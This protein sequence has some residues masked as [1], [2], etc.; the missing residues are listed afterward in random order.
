MNTILF[1]EGGF[2]GSEVSKLIFN[3]KKNKPKKKYKL[4]LA[5]TN[6][7]LNYLE[8]KK[9]DLIINCAVKANFNVRNSN[10]MMKVN[11]LA[12][13][14]M[15]KYCIK[16]K[17]TLIQVSGTIVH[18]NLSHYNIKSK[19]KP[20]NFYGKTKLFADKF[21]LKNRSK[22][23]FKIIRFGGIYGL[24]GPDHLFLNKLINKK[25]KFFSGNLAAI[26]NY[27]HVKDA[28]SC[29]KKLTKINRSGIYY[30]GGQKIDFENMI[31]ILN[32]RCR[33]NINTINSI[34]KKSIEIVKTDS[35]FKP[36]SF[37]CYL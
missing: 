22:I 18:P 1:G 8:S 9:P 23:N 19:I 14:E 7:I 34:K 16:N 35:I 2:L 31:K 5:K 3:I 33:L 4:D 29:I 10:Q 36:K 26:K 28:A 37:G 11:Y 21:I 27:I 25:K 12:V 20:K 24:N 15:V 17:K 30:A 6:L 13:K 32:K